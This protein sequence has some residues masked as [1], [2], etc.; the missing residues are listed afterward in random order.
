MAKKQKQ[1]QKVMLL[2]LPNYASHIRETDNNSKHKQTK[3]MNAEGCFKGKAQDTI[4]SYVE[5]L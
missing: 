1:K 2:A 3:M 5:R 4:N